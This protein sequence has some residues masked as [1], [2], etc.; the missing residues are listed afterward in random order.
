VSLWHAA[1]FAA[2]LGTASHQFLRCR[3]HQT[4]RAA[5]SLRAL[6]WRMETM[7]MASTYP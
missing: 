3:V 7:S 6:A 1:V 4:P 2:I 5:S